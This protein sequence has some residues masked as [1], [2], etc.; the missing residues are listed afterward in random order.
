M[1]VSREPRGLLPPFGWSQIIREFHLPSGWS[2]LP[3]GA[4]EFEVGSSLNVII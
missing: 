1:V 3:V 2:L 4:G